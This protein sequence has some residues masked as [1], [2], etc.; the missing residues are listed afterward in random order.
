MLVDRHR[1]RLYITDSTG[2]L[3]VL[4]ATSYRKLATLP[5]TGA[6]EPIHG[7]RGS[8]TLDPS[9]DRL[10]VAAETRPAGVVTAVDT[11][12][13][14]IVGSIT[15]GGA[16]SLDTR[17]NRLYIGRARFDN[18]IHDPSDAALLEGTGRVYDA[19]SLQALA[20]LPVQGRPVYNPLADELLIVSFTV[21]RVDPD[22]LEIMGDLLPDISAQPCP[23]CN[24]V[25]SARKAWVDVEHN[26][27]TVQLGMSSVGHPPPC[28]P[29]DRHFDAT[30]LEPVS[31]PGITPP[32]EPTCN[33]QRQL[34][35][36][37][38]ERTYTS[39][40]CSDYVDY[41]E[42]WVFS[43]DGER[44]ATLDGMRL[45]LVNPNTCQSYTQVGERV[46][47]LDLPA[48]APVGS[49]PLAD[50]TL[51]AGQKRLYGLAGTDLLVFDEQGGHPELL[52]P[53]AAALP[54]G[55]ISLIRPSANYAEDRTIFVG[56][57]TPAG[58]PFNLY[59]ILFRSTDG[60]ETWALLRGGLPQ[61]QGVG[62]DLAVSPGF[63]A[64]QT[65]FAGGF[66]NTGEGL[67]VFRSTD[68]GD[69]W[70]PVSEGLRH[71][72]VDG[73]LLSPDYPVDGT[74]LAYARAGSAVAPSGRAVYRSTD[75]GDHWTL[76]SRDPLPDPAELLPSSVHMPGVQFRIA[77]NGRG[78]E[79]WTAS[80]RTWQQVLGTGRDDDGLVAVLPSPSLD[81]DQTVWVLTHAGL[82][83][84]TDAG[85]SWAY[86]PRKRLDGR[87]RGHW[88]T[89]GA[90]AG[91]RLFVGTRAGEFF[92]LDPARRSCGPG[93][94]TAPWPTILA[95]EWVRRIEI[96]PPDWPGPGDGG[97]IWLATQGSGVYRYAGGAIQ[98][99]YTVADD[100]PSRDIWGLALAPDVPSVPGTGGALWVAG[101]DPLEVVRFDGQAWTTHTPALP[102]DYPWVVDLAAT[103]DGT[104]WGITVLSGGTGLP[105]SAL[106]RWTGTQWTRVEDP[107]DQLDSL[108]YDVTAGED[109]SI[110]VA[111]TSGLARYQAGN[112][113]SFELGEC[114][115]VALG[116]AGEA[117]CVTAEGQV[118]RYAGQA[119]NA[120]PPLPA[121]KPDSRALQVTR[122]GAVWIGTSEGL[123]RYDDRGWHPFAWPHDLQGSV[124]V[125]ECLA[126]DADGQLWLGTNNGA[127]HLDPG[128]LDPRLVPGAGP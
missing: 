105:E 50:Y 7:V 99:H 65:T 52:P 94:G 11:A 54:G 86:C 13:L 18:V 41:N 74:L 20:D 72:R 21:L 84:S 66:L 5:V 39:R 75:R 79:R 111:T 19:P 12:T 51:D 53:E 46:V 117:Y 124:S 44:I 4:D 68:G 76:V 109:G 15:P 108:V 38:G 123:A 48:L 42:I 16:V 60:G 104:V 95:G 34:P 121:G 57:S 107:S 55:E 98:A 93:E 80:T 14:A 87:D 40:V 32:F 62:W 35:A 9:H 56:V 29:G 119:W 45:G 101:Q 78:V 82:F 97:D 113:N 64:D 3:H 88:V 96:A 26:L 83:R 30:T 127:I 115:A 1:A 49:L 112:W 24:G 31:D 61:D 28:G 33:E 89:A 6:W 58:Y 71:L 8:L 92:S 114:G 43:P 125:L 23:Q 22:T 37:L 102:G 73:L 25:T 70:Q 67:G 2:M 77:A 106:L 27:L 122:D 17:R 63:A 69:T 103:P 85:E 120:L 128:T 36:S 47:V 110:W 59:S 100:L 10:Y 91:G 81:V 116:L 118:W 126:E 90:M